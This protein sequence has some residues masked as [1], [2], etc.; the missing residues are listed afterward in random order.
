MATNGHN[1]GA[2]SGAADAVLKRSDPV[3][4]E[5][6]EVQGIE[7]NEY[8]DRSITVEELVAGMTTMGFQA[9]SVGEAVEIIEGMVVAPL[10]SMARPRDW[11]ED[12]DI[13]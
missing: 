4:E 7:F 1:A 3:S 5:A 8:A 11:R 10:Q 9:T 6:R 2:P 12:D 13:P